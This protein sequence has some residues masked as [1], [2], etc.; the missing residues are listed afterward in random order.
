MSK[1]HR[2][3]V[4]LNPISEKGLELL[5]PNYELTD[6]PSTAHAWIVRSAKLHDKELPKSLRAISRAGAGVNNIPLERC[7]EQG[8]VVFNTPGANANGVCELVLCAM[9]LASRDVLGGAQWVC[10][11]VNNKDIS[12]IAESQVAISRDRNPR[13]DARCHWLRC[14][15]AL[16]C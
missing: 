15:W 5:R 2:P 10:Q 12:S 8:I 16:S 7:T 1:V 13:Q 4:C 3:I 6:D 9:I 11:H 14:Y